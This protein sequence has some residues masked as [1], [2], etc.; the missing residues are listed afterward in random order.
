MITYNEKKGVLTFT[1]KDEALVRKYAK[2]HK[3]TFRDVVY[4]AIINGIAEGYFEAAKEAK[5]DV[6]TSQVSSCSG[7]KDV[8]MVT[9]KKGRVNE[10]P[11]RK[12]PVQMRDL[13]S[14]SWNCECDHCSK[15][16][17]A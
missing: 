5:K 7:K 9:R 15:Q 11:N 8:A 12:R 3:L 2:E 6:V 14:N 1:G 4:L 10:G 16:K 17:K 13:P